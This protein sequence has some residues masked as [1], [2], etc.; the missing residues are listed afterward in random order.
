[1]SDLRNRLLASRARVSAASHRADWQRGFTL[2]ELLVVL[3]ILGL[4]VGFVTPQVLKYLGRAKTDAA[5]I[6][7]ENIAGALDLFRLDVGRYPTQAEGLAALVEHPVGVDS[8]SGPYL[9]QKAVPPDPWSRPYIYKIPGD[10]GDYDLYT[11][12]A[13]GVPGGTGENQSVTNW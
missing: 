7:I 11:L 3:V 8:W 2:I 12:G 4:I 5:H 9:K 13:A 1:M 10:H 6:Q